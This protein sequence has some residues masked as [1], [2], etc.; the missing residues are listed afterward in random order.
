[1]H[2]WTRRLTFHRS[3]SLFLAGSSSLSY[4]TPSHTDPSPR[5]AAKEGR[6]PENPES[7]DLRRYLGPRITHIH[8]WAWIC[9]ESTHSLWKLRRCTF[10]V[11]RY[12]RAAGLQPTYSG[13]QPEPS[14]NTETKAAFGVLS[15][16]GWRRDSMKRGV[17]KRLSHKDGCRSLMS[18]IARRANCCVRSWGLMSW[19]KM[20]G[21]N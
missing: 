17:K 5:L 11:R 14:D 3:L 1:M 19:G 7:R 2:C 16:A 18:V 21:R 15:T 13:Q 4:N 10:Y 12:S 20:L 8:S 9:S 6:C